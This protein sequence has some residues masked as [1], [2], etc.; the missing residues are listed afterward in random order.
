[1]KV[2]LTATFKELRQSA[3]GGQ[4]ALLAMPDGSTLWVTVN[5]A[6]DLRTRVEEALRTVIRNSVVKVIPTPLDGKK[7]E[8]EEEIADD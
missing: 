5:P 6:D 4:E 8:V 1:M 3:G 2:K 7:I